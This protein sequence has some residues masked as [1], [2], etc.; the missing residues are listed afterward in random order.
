M[1]VLELTPI[2]VDEDLQPRVTTD[3]NISHEY[4]LAMAR[5]DVFPPV[6]VFW[7]GETYW[8]ADGFHRYYAAAALGLAEIDCTVHQGSYDDALWFSCAANSKNGFHRNE[9]DLQLVA[10]R[11]LLHPN[12]A[13]ESDGVVS[14]HIGCSPSVVCRVRQRLIA[15][16]SLTNLPSRIGKNGVEQVVGC[17]GKAKAAPDPEPGPE[18]DAE[19][20]EP[21]SA[22][23]PSDQASLGRGQT[24]IEDLPGVKPTAKVVPMI[25][26]KWEHLPANIGA[27]VR[28]HANLPDPGVAA[29]NFPECLGHTL[30]IRDVE[31]VIRWW[32][33]FLPLWRARQPEL[34]RYLERITAN[35]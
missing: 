10:E 17:R 33:G 27:I 4:G 8:L 20:E 25:D 3:H 1:S 31:A 29:A 30:D 14:A 35:R 16:S 32:Q 23:D 34:K 24:D 18:P 9:S 22:P 15:G 26:P 21:A 7:D 13:G 5:G 19:Q 12:A 2:E 11:A 6:D 28:A